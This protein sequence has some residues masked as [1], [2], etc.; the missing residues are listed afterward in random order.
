[1]PPDRAPLRA[2]VTTCPT[3]GEEAEAQE[4][5][6][7][8]DVPCQ[9]YDGSVGT[10]SGWRKVTRY[11]STATDP[12][13]VA[14]MRELLGEIHDAL[15]RSVKRANRNASQTIRWERLESADL[16]RRIA[17]LLPATEDAP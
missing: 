13:Q 17:A 16:Q 4:I 12:V 10:G 3:C 15:D 1:M 6:E 7:D 9:H 5:T 11:R 14:A 2:A 8:F